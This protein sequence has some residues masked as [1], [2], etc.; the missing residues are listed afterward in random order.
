[1]IRASKPAGQPSSSSRLPPLR[2]MMA[3]AIDK[4][5]PKL[6]RLFKLRASSPRVERLDDALFFS[7]GNPRTVILNFDD[8]GLLLSQNP[9][10]NGGSKLDRVVHQVFNGAH[11]LLRITLNVKMR[12]AAVVK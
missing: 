8:R 5:K 9:N 10:R 3:C 2:S 6:S 11:H 12:A 4:P 1:M 7:V